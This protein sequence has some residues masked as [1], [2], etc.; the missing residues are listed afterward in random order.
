MT[1]WQI[2]SINVFFKKKEL[3]HTQKTDKR[4]IAFPFG[5]RT[6]LIYALTT[7]TIELKALNSNNNNNN[8][9]QKNN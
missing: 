3:H 6:S 4:L 2:K 8:K 5:L 1:N 7:F 9:G